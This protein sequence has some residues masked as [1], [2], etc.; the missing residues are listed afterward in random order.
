[1]SADLLTDLHG[2]IADAHERPPE[3]RHVVAI[4]EL[5]ERFSLPVDQLKALLAALEAQPSVT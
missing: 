3:D 1:M 4:Q 5:A 2:E